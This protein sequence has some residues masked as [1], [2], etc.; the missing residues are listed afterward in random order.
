MLDR[1]A[2]AAGPRMVLL[3]WEGSMRRREFIITLGGAAT[4]AAW[5]L[6]IGA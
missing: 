6:A 3:K 4:T 2:E 1:I 5:P